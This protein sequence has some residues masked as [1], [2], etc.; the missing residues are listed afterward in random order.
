MLELPFPEIRKTGFREGCGVKI[1]SSVF[2][3]L[4]CEIPFC[5]HSGIVDMGFGFG[6]QGEVWVR[7]VNLGVISI[8]M[9]LKPGDQIRTLR[10][11]V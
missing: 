7:D 4:K 6:I 2:G 3:W 5:S 9:Y 10:E 8:R 1:R 11:W